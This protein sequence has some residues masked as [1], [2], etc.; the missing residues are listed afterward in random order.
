MSSSLVLYEPYD[1]FDT[2]TQSSILPPPHGFPRSASSAGTNS[3]S[4][5]GH[6]HIS[7]KHGLD[8]KFTRSPTPIGSGSPIARS[9]QRFHTPALHS[10]VSTSAT[11]LT[12][13]NTHST[14]VP[15][16]TRNEAPVP[17]LEHRLHTP[18]LPS[19]LSM[20]AAVL[21]ANNAHSTRV[22]ALCSFSTSPSPR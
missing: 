13:N 20:S 4:C 21:A 15:N 7:H 3:V 2:P 11:L 1:S 16:V 12:A 8:Q 6:D 10:T 9:E 18:V 5:S 17:R 14:R 22:L 19:K